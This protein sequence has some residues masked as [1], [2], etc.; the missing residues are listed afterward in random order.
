MVFGSYNVLLRISKVSRTFPELRYLC[1]VSDEALTL[2]L[3]ADGNRVF[4]HAPRPMG[5][6]TRFDW[7][8][9]SPGHTWRSRARS[10]DKQRIG[11]LF[12]HLA[13]GVQVPNP[14]PAHIRDVCVHTAINRIKYYPGL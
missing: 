6:A 8:V 12:R 9:E 10:G 1:L 7:E 14:L 4:D 2:D 5:N 3:P 13:S 11:K